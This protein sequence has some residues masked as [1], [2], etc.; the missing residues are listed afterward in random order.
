MVVSNS[1]ACMVPTEGWRDEVEDAARPCSTDAGQSSVGWGLCTERLPR[2]CEQ[3]GTWCHLSG[4]N[5]EVLGRQTGEKKQTKKIWFV[6]SEDCM[7]CLRKRLLSSTLFAAWEWWAVHFG[8][9]SLFQA[10][11]K[12]PKLSI[13]VGNQ[14]KK[15]QVALHNDQLLKSVR[16]QNFGVGSC[17][18]L[19]RGSV[20]G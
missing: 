5:S 15:G 2:K 11:T 17:Q 14:Q 12:N 16:K 18:P 1:P 8:T 6:C 19:V 3:R 7:R 20:R 10:M 4:S 13:N 9:Q